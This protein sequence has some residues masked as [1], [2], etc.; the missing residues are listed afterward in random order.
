MKIEN[1][2][3]NVCRDRLPQT[4]RGKF[5][6]KEKQKKV[7]NPG[8]KGGSPGLVV[9]G[10]DSCYEGGEFE[11]QHRILDG[12]LSHIFVVRIVMVFL[13]WANPGL[14]LF[15]FVLFSLQF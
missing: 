15:I 2:K 12:H 6:C 9:M 13:K 7:N 8:K 14:F 4:C 11:S 1:V 10:G 5:S 3:S